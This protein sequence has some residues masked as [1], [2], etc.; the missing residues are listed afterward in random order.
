MGGVSRPTG[1]SVPLSVAN[2]PHRELS[3]LNQDFLSSLWAW[4][5]AL[6]LL[7]WF[8]KADCTVREDPA[9]RTAKV[10]AKS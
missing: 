7:D 9:G 6:R 5:Q 8:P 4:Q 2:R 3:D 10:S 1:P